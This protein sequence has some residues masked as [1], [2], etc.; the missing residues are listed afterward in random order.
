MV[1]TIS[2]LYSLMQLIT[3]SFLSP[4]I[5][6]AKSLPWNIANLVRNKAP[7]LQDLMIDLREAAPV[8]MAPV[9]GLHGREIT[10]SFPG[11]ASQFTSHTVQTGSVVHTMSYPLGCLGS[12]VEGKATGTS[13]VPRTSVQ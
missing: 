5:Y 8:N 9:F 10:T 3:L 2:E 1:E 6:F 4:L 12:L 13:S 11:A 7:H